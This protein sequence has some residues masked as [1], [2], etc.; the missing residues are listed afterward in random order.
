MRTEGLTKEK[1]VKEI[2]EIEE[3]LAHLRL[4]VEENWRPVEIADIEGAYSQVPIGERK[5]ELQIG[6]KVKVLNPKFGQETEG[7]VINKRNPDTGY[8]TIQGKRFRRKIVRVESNVQRIDSFS[9]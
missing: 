3:R 6:D 7:R 8:V 2:T 4:V 9:K 5:I 1:V